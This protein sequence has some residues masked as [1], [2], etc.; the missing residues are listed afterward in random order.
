MK[1]YY[2]S[3]ASKSKSRS[4]FFQ[5]TLISITSTLPVFFLFSNYIATFRNFLG[6]SDSDGL[7]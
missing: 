3:T 2:E 5:F 6:V 1:N 4:S 7:S